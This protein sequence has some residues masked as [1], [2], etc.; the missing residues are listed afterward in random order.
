MSEPVQVVDYQYDLHWIDA[1][2]ARTDYG[3]DG[4][5]VAGLEGPISVRLADG[6]EFRVEGSGRWHARYG[7]MG[8]GQVNMQ[9]RTSDGRVGNAAYEITGTSH[10]HFFPVARAENYPPG[11]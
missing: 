1:S 9:L 5:N 6:R 8:G 7:Q 3:R 10:H 4:E 2:G 11:P